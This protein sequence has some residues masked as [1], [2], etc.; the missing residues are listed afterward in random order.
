MQNNLLNKAK[1]LPNKPG[2]YLMKK[3]KGTDE[4][5]LYVGKA[6]NLRKRVSSYFNNSSKSPK[7]E[8]LVSH[9]NDFDFIMTDTDSEAFVLEN[10][11]I[12]KHS[13]KYNIRLKDDKSYPYII[14]NL[15]ED[16]PRLVYE[17][18]PSKKKG[19]L[20][21]GPFVVGSNISE[22]LRVL[23]KSFN[24]RDC[25]LKEFNSR[26]EPCLLYQMKQCSAP[27]VDLIN[28][29]DYSKDLDL[30]L[31]FFRGSGREGV[32]AL[33]EKMFKYA[34]LEQFERAA[35]LRDNIEILKTFLEGS[36]QTNAE[37]SSSVKNIDIVAYHVGEVEIDISLYMMR[38][39]V[40]LG[41]K[42]FHFPAIDCSDSYDDE[43][44]Q[45]IFQYYSSTFDKMPDRVITNFSNEINEVLSKAFEQVHEIKVKCTG[46][47][48]KFNSLMKLTMDHAF[49]HQR[50]RILN[51]D[52]TYIGLN[53]LKDLL[54]LRERPVVLECYD[55]AIFQGK[56]PT[57]SQIVFTDG[58]ADKSKYR[59][60]HL[61]ERPEG[62]NDFAMMSEVINRRIKKG[63]LPDIFVVDGG[64]GQ[65]NIFLGALK[66]HNVEVPVVGIAKS[67]VSKKSTFKSKEV[68]RTDERLI[69]PGRSNPFQLSKCKSL[70]RILTQM[71]DEAH[72]F[73]RR[74]H[75]KEEKRKLIS[76]WIDQVEGVGPITKKKIISRL[77]KSVSELKLMNERDI[78]SY[79]EV[80]K[81]VAKA[82]VKTLALK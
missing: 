55:I 14:V 6:K 20:V 73:S 50:V 27:C 56:S 60:F 2:C 9:I 24:L 43:V 36:K 75:H 63:N 25:S 57:A 12:K 52:S 19:Q 18:R 38:E 70:F 62:N 39:G 74:L 30:A 41:H 76:S 71:R 4:I 48:R 46:A 10:N 45:Y 66:D 15:N 54:G 72:R 13:P 21:F 1:T 61:E 28:K 51:E 44:A 35:L 82:I 23:T 65:V 59:H 81:K 58:R 49:E 8:I 32:L 33:E 29:S 11:L 34:E 17:R 64:I 67:K 5:I 47:G 80:S 40:L 53:R 42:N 31:S 7:T 16:F 68:E 77:D 3:A 69:I 26:K 79:F 37:I 78:E 22:V